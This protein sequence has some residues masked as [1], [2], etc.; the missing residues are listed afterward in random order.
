MFDSA[1]P[2]KELSNGLVVPKS[3]H[4]ITDLKA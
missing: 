4:D 1:W 3:P 2:Q